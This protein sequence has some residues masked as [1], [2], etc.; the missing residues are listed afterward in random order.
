[1]FRLYAKSKRRILTLQN[2]KNYLSPD[3]F[4]AIKYYIH[5]EE[6]II[7]FRKAQKNKIL[8]SHVS[9]RLELEDRSGLLYKVETRFPM[10]DIRLIEYVLSLPYSEKMQP[11]R[12]RL[13]YRNAMTGIL[14]TSIINRTDKAILMQPFAKEEL[15]NCQ[16]E[17]KPWLQLLEERQQIP[18]YI[19]FKK[20][21]SEYSYEKEGNSIIKGS[22][23]RKKIENIV[24][25]ET[26][27]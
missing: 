23:M 7:H 2:E 3:Y 22:T 8:A 19:N 27:F 5:P 14:P 18:S 4:G 13:L 24:R 10:A 26:R 6:L 20:L 9:E 17:I 11:A 16:K 21:I 15:F 12:G 25:W 1:L